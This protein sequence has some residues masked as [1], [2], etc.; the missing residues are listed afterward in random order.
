MN[1]TL[2]LS[3]FLTASLHAADA[4]SVGRHGNV[5]QV[6]LVEAARD[7][8]LTLLPQHS[9]F[10]GGKGAKLE[11]EQAAPDELNGDKVW[12]SIGGLSSPDQ[13]IVFRCA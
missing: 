4:V 12:K 10:S 9:F 2:L 1:R 7:G 6:F 3:L 11:G 5:E 8:M 13:R